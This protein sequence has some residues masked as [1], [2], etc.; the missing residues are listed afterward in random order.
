MLEVLAL[1]TVVMVDIIISVIINDINDIPD[2]SSDTD[3]HKMNEDD[4]EQGENIYTAA[5]QTHTSSI[6]IFSWF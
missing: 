3:H 1:V 4:W 2:C 5:L 6:L